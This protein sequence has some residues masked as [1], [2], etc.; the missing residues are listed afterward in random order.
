MTRPD[1]I[2]M[3]F[4]NAVKHMEAATRGTQAYIIIDRADPYK[5]GRVVISRRASV[6]AIAWLPGWYDG[7]RTDSARTIRHHGR[8]NG[9]G[10]DMATAAMGG[11][12]YFDVDGRRC[13]IADSGESWDRQLQNAGYIVVQ[14][15]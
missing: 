1:Q 13:V 8:A 7:G 5:W 10:Y 9:G 12:E 14:A 11:A 3:K 2:D 4:V 15:V 6:R